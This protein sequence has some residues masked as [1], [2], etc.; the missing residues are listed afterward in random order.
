MRT[1]KLQ[2]TKSYRNEVRTYTSDKLI[3]GYQ[4]KLK[5]H[6]LNKYKRKEKKEKINRN[7]THDIALLTIRRHCKNRV[8]KILVMQRQSNYLGAT[9]AITETTLTWKLE[10]TLLSYSSV[11]DCTCFLFFIYFM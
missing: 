11:K 5:L 1:E 8:S 9:L 4:E 2:I 3:F 10:K 6:F 7:V